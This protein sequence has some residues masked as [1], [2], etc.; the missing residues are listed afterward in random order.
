MLN[1][2]QVGRYNGILHKLL[3][4]KEGSPSPTL[5]SDLFP[6]ICL[7][8]ERPE[9]AFLAGDRLGLAGTSIAGTAGQ[10]VSIVLWNPTGSNILTVTELIEYWGAAGFVGDIRYYDADPPGYVALN[11]YPRDSR[12]GWAT[13]IGTTATRVSWASSA[14]VDGNL[15]ARLPMAVALEKYTITQPFILKPGRAL[16]LV[17]GLAQ[18]FGVNFYWRE[19]ALSPSETR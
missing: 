4:M 3:D 9:W 7:E 1:E 8:G 14:G 18:Q 2:I 11:R 12:T 5:A 15:V 19:R 13:A 17:G 10:Y 6:T 16:I